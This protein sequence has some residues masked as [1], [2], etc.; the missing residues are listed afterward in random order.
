MHPEE[1]GWS[2]WPR[3]WLISNPSSKAEK[4]K[5]LLNQGVL[6]SLEKTIGASGQQTHS[7]DNSHLI[8][9]LFGLK[10]ITVLVVLPHGNIRDS[11]EF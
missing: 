11:I 1:L 10:K 7:G 3:S 4:A 5:T 8:L 2:L 9:L 6:L